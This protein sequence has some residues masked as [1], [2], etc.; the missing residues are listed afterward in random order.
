M[1][2]EEDP[3]KGESISSID[4]EVFEKEKKEFFESDFN[5]EAAAW[6]YGIL[7][8][9]VLSFLVPAIYVFVKH[10]VYALKSNFIWV[11]TF[12]C[13]QFISFAI[14][15]PIIILFVALHISRVR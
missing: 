1:D 5:L 10:K 9:L 14:V 6:L 13:G 4:S 7:G 3:A 8:F 11:A 12:F 2:G 15:D